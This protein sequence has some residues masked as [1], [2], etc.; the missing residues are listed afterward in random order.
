VSRA[1]RNNP[2]INPLTKEFI[3]TKSKELNYHP[4]FYAS[5]LRDKKTKTIAVIL[6]ELANNFFSQAVKGIEQVASEKGYHTLIYV[7]DSDFKKEVSIIE[8]LSN[9]RVDGVIMSASGEGA[10]HRYINRL[11]EWH[12][13]VVFFDRVYDD[14]NAPKVITN[15][16]ESSFLATEH[17]IKA[18]CKK[19]ALLVIDKS[20]S[21][22]KIRMAGY[23]DALQKHNIP[24]K[25]E[26]VV[27]CSNDFNISYEI[28]GTLL[29]TIKPDGLLTTVERLA[30]NAYHVCRDKKIAIP[31][32]VKI[33]SYSSLEIAAL[34]NPSLS[35]ITQPALD[36]GK[37]AAMLLFEDLRKPILISDVEPVVLKSVIIPRYSTGNA[38]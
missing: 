18:G 31:E 5:S 3:L 37:R 4:N 25:D 7:T 12:I 16:Y 10:D 29:S 9:G 34:L 13:S 23:K 38:G 6:P 35:T 26:W 27:D 2:D 11:K 21:I 19:I 22:G 8:N 14:I 32:D 24:L 20:L 33:I 17:L 30:T 36:M 15:D 28:I 1:F